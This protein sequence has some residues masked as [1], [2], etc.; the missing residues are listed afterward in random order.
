MRGYLHC[1]LFNCEPLW[2]RRGSQESGSSLKAL[3]E[4]KAAEA[5][6]KKRK[7]MEEPSPPSRPGL[8]RSVVWRG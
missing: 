3:M 4:K 6:M 2:K 1:V 7:F 8:H 5:V